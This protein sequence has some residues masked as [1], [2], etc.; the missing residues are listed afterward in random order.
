M[1]KEDIK[2]LNGELSI[3]TMESKLI[4]RN[5][6]YVCVVLDRL[7][8]VQ[9]NQSKAQSTM[10][11]LLEKNMSRVEVNQQKIKTIKGELSKGVSPEVKD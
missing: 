1:K 3:L 8:E 5:I 10:V 7:I 2:R 9:I 4:A 11:A 6:D